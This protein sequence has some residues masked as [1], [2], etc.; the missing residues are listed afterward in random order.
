MNKT[1]KIAGVGTLAL[2]AGAAYQRRNLR[3][4]QQSPTAI[5]TEQAR[6]LLTRAAPLLR[7][8]TSPNRAPD[9]LPDGSGVR[10]PST[11]RVYPYRNGILDLL[12]HAPELTT[13]QHTLNT[14][15][16]AWIYDRSR[17][18][19]LRLGGAPSFAQEV[20]MTQ[21]Q[22]QI[23]PG[24]TVLDLACGHGNF[25]VEWARRAGP[26]GLIIGLDISPAM[27]QRAAMR[28][29][30][31]GLANILLIRGDA[32]QL[33]VTHNVFAKVN[34]SGGFHQLPDL[35]GALYEIARVS[36]ADAV[37]T[38]STFAEGP[39]DQ[40]AALK[41]WF[42]R[43]FQLHFVPLDWLETQLAQVGYG[44]YRAT[45]AGRWFGYAFVRKTGADSAASSTHAA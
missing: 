33:P 42:K 16:T 35:P 28:V 32:Q 44:D 22:L 39:N 19:I 2:V 30:Q 17:D 5:T 24:D 3:N 12:Q 7:L 37:L 10:C 23:K 29:A 15:I 25:T 34:C 8:P 43:R 45:L 14:R 11:G 20:T 38:A 40:W 31:A 18:A 21:A 1:L 9:V 27:L 6:Q 26:D 13:T 41:H 36:T 4:V